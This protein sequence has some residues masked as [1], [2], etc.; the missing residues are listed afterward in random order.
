MPAEKWDV[1]DLGCGTGLVGAH[2]APRARR[3][4]GV[5]VSSR[6]L[7]KARSRGI[8]TR[9]IEADI[10]EMLRAEPADSYD[11]VTAGDV[12]IYV[13]RMDD[14]V[15]QIQRVL[16][17]GSMFA[18]SVESPD[19]G[20]DGDVKL[21]TSAR[22]G[23][24][25]AYLARLAATLRFEVVENQPARIRVEMGAPVPGFIALWKKPVNP[26]TAS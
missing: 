24:S 23:Q 5:D 20:D 16:R 10:A 7:Q 14:I 22:F 11:L 9:L 3:L 17:P 6:M 19:A 13:G 2:V 21:K 15:A 18:F 1:L 26:P 4:V 25:Q 12:F 8:Y